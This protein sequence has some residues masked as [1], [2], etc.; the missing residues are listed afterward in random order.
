[1]SLNAIA[2]F[3]T[4][5]GLARVTGTGTD[6]YFSPD[7]SRDLSPTDAH[8]ALRRFLYD[9]YRFS[10]TLEVYAFLRPLS[11]AHT[12]N[13]SW[14]SLLPGFL[15][16]LIEIHHRTVLGGWSSELPDCIHPSLHA[17]YFSLSFCCRLVV[18]R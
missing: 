14:V 7:S 1:M 3:L 10:T 5:D 4:A 17:Y 2:P 6:V 11:S 9:D 8:A 13:T 16:W 12:A 18:L 15:M